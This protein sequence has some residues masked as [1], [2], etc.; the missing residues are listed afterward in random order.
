MDD[1]YIQVVV[2]TRHFLSF[3]GASSL[4]STKK[5]YVMLCLY[6]SQNH[7]TKRRD[8]NLL[9]PL[10]WWLSSQFK[11]IG[12][13]LEILFI[14]NIAVQLIQINCLNHPTRKRLECVKI[15]QKTLRHCHQASFTKCLAHTFVK[16]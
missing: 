6:F 5:L 3:L 2:V 16:C 11:G 13:V 10:L 14:F 7:R 1:T 9:T 15:F 12:I 8:K 4:D